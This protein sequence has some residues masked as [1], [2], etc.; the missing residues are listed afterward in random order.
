MKK[1]HF[2]KWP[3][4]T[5]LEEDFRGRVPLPVSGFT[6]FAE[7]FFGIIAEFVLLIKMP[8]ESIKDKVDG[9]TLDLSLNDLLVVPVKEIVSFWNYRPDT[10]AIGQILVIDP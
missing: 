4:F 5:K 3:S 6:I 9:N 7:K 8:K 1:Y 10:Y 2:W